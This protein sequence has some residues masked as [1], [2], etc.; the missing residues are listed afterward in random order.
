MEDLNLMVNLI[1]KKKHPVRAFVKKVLKL[2][3]K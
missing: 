1:N 2:F 3:S